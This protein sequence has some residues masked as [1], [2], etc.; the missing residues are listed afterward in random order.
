M[1]SLIR[2]E[3]FGP[4]MGFPSIRDSFCSTPY[5]GEKAIVEYLMRGETTLQS[6]SMAKDKITG[7]ILPIRLCLM[8]D[9]EYS[10][11]SSLAYHVEKYHLR[12]DP[13][14]EKKVLASTR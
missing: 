10:W 11:A 6:T 13:E 7:E 14:F 5:E 2:Y 4:G 3:E 12:L 9:G 8:S 1:K